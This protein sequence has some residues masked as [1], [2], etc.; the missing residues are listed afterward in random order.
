MKEE[1]PLTPEA[2]SQELLR[3]QQE[4]QQHEQQLQGAPVANMMGA[5][6]GMVQ[7]GYGVMGLT[8]GNGIQ[9]NRINEEMHEEM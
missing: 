9:Q 4:Q 3:R 5:G 1:P 7:T 6:P 2:Q 8:G